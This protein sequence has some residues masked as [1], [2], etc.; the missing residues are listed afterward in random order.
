MGLL[1]RPL[2]VPLREPGIEIDPMRVLAL[3]QID[4]PVLQRLLA[5]D[6]LLDVAELLEIDEHRYAVAAGEH[7]SLA[8]A[9]EL[10]AP[11]DVVGDADIERPARWAGKDEPCPQP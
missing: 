2:S 8:C 10:D 4:L 5:L 1:R 9:M 6:G 11:Q 7:G 3:D